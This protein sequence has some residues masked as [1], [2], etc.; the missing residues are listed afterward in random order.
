MWGGG[1]GF[2]PGTF[3]GVGIFVGDLLGGW[4][5]KIINPWSRGVVGS[6]IFLGIWRVRIQFS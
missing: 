1:R 6:Y 5:S 2:G 3:G 4:G